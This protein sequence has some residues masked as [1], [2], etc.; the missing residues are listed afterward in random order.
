MLDN[1]TRKMAYADAVCQRLMSV[2]GVGFVTALT[3]KAGVDD[4]HR[5]KHSPTVDAHIG[6]KHNR[7]PA[8]LPC[9]QHNAI[10]TASLTSS[11]D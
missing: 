10:V 1:R 3:F 9:A 4:P 2:S 8:L 11:P 7:L 5:F 6:R